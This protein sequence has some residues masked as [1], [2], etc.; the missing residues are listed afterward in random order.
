MNKDE[1]LITSSQND[2]HLFSS[3]LFSSLLSLDQAK[4]K[5]KQNRCCEDVIN[6]FLC[7]LRSVTNLIS[8]LHSL[9]DI[10]ERKTLT[11]KKKKM[12]PP[13]SFDE[14][15]RSKINRKS[16]LSDS[17]SNLTVNASYHRTP[18]PPSNRCSAYFLQRLDLNN[19]TVSTLKQ[20]VDTNIPS[21]SRAKGFD[22]SFFFSILRTKSNPM[23]DSFF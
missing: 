7:F 4:L 12:F 20:I 9:I 11:K 2:F 21:D 19:Y 3:L 6:H 15:K 1:G 5:H 14:S 13:M 10:C 8:N 18:S 17:K 23:Y 16:H 22:Q